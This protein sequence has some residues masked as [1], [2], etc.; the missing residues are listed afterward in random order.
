MDKLLESANY[1]QTKCKNLLIPLSSI[2]LTL[3]VL[4]LQVLDNV[5]QTRWKI[6]PK[7]QRQGKTK[8][9]RGM[10]EWRAVEQSIRHHTNLNVSRNSKF[11]CWLHHPGLIF[12]RKFESTKDSNQQTESCVGIDIE[13]RLAP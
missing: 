7:E 10:Q 3:S 2:S 4:G 6:L 5:I 11:R 9:R 12:T 13:A 8:T 1:P